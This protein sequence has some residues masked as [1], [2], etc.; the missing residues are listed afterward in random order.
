MPARDGEGDNTA[1]A[2][3]WAAEP[4]ASNRQYAHRSGPCTPEGWHDQS[5]GVA[6]PAAQS[7]CNTLLAYLKDVDSFKIASRVLQR[8]CAAGL[9]AH[10]VLLN[11]LLVHSWCAGDTVC[12]HA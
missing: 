5:G 3:T 4:Q 12:R 10:R 7:H 2:Q 6:N 9:H 11:L 1:C 8:N